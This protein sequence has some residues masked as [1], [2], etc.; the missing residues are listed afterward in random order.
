MDHDDFDTALIASAMTLAEEKGWASVSVLDAARAAGLPLAE[1]RQ[2]FPFRVSVL[3]GLGR[4]ADNAAL[5]DDMISGS[6]RE[7]LFDLL[8][9]RLDV[10]QQ[11]RHG[12][13]SV[14]RTLPLD[15]PM[16]ILLGGATL[17]SMRW[18]ADAAGIGTPG[19]GGLARVNMVVGIWAHTLRA[20]DKDESP[21]MGSTMAALE[22]GL[23]KA[24]RFGLFPAGQAAALEDT[25][26]PDL[27]AD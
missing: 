1:A 27:P 25:G 23:D 24:A 5:S 6:A 21:D 14:L 3:L 15:P 11:Y 10:F 13:R 26:L 9:R 17:E 8:M 22:Q 12:V 7:R 18:M 19:L 4:M 2:R 20:W 16:A